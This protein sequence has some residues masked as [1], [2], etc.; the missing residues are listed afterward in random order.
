LRQEIELV[1]IKKIDATGRFLC[2]SKSRDGS[3]SFTWGE[4]Q[5]H[6]HIAVLSRMQANTRKDHCAAE[7]QPEP[8]TRDCRQGAQ[9]L[10]HMVHHMQNPAAGHLSLLPIPLIPR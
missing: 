8:R 3:L 10:T 7:A 9:H 4:E 5:L 6:F 2:A 1:G